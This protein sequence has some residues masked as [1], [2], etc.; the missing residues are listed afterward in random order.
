MNKERIADLVD[1]N[2]YKGYVDGFTTQTVVDTLNIKMR[3]LKSVLLKENPLIDF[4]NLV[5]SNDDCESDSV[6]I[7][8]TIFYTRH[9]IKRI[10]DLAWLDKNKPKLKRYSNSQIFNLIKLKEKLSI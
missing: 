4:D 8:Y 10:E 2:I 3:N 9:S 7:R 6:R 1:K 5:K